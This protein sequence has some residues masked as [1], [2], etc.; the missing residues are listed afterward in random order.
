M[1]KSHLI[2]ALTAAVLSF[3]SIS[4]YA[5]LITFDGGTGMGTSVYVEN[6]FNFTA[7]SG[8]IQGPYEGGL[9]STSIWPSSVM[10][11]ATDGSLFDVSS[12]FV[13]TNNSSVVNK[14]I[15]FTGFFDTGSITKSFTVVGGTNLAVQVLFSGFTALNAFEMTVPFTTFDNMDVSVSEVPVPAALLM[16]GP[17]LLGFM[18]LRRKAKVSV[19]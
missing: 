2:G 9:V 12:I 10:V 1:N 17:A 7:S 8:V 18:G 11:T 19:A 4:S 13:D 16:F 6:G 5:S 3:I 14:T 15:N